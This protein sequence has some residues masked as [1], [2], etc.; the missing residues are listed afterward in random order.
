MPSVA[1]KSGRHH[2]A[3]ETFL[4]QLDAASKI[5]LISLAT[6]ATGLRQTVSAFCPYFK[7]Y[8]L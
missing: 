1:N 8:K 6:K 2:F 4:Q 5:I 3:V 7:E